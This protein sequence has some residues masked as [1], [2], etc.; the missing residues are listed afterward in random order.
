MRPCQMIVT[1]AAGRSVR[2][3]VGDQSA[4]ANSMMD[5]LALGMEP[6]S[7]AELSGEPAAVEQIAA[8]FANDFAPSGDPDSA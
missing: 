2:L 7:Q 8:M 4:D 5:L 6:N 3:H 1:A